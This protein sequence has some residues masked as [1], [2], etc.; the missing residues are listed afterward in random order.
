MAVFSGW[1]PFEFKVLRQ[2]LSETG[3]GREGLHLSDVLNRMGKAIGEKQYG[4]TGWDT[5]RMSGFVWE[6]AVEYMAAGMD[7][8][9]AMDAAFRR[10]LRELRKNVITQCAGEKD[11]IRMTP[12][13]L[14]VDEGVVESYKSTHRKMPKTQD[15]FEEKFWKWVAQEASYC[16]LLGVDTARWIVL[17]NRG[18]YGAE[19]GPVVMQATMTWTPEEL[20]ERWKV[21]VMHAEACKLEG[22]GQ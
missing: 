16:Y 22:I 19:R 2:D 3:S 8:D 1:S 20:A 11:G 12:D 6:T 5:F 21:I 17:W 10:H 4:E 13:A 9:S 7:H 15:E 14:V 18:D